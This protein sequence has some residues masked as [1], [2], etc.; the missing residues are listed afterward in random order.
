VSLDSLEFNLVL[1]KQLF[2]EVGGMER[3]ELVPLTCTIVA[4]VPPSAQFFANLL[5]EFL[6][7]LTLQLIQLFLFEFELGKKNQFITNAYRLH[8]N[9]LSLRNIQTF[10][11]KW[12]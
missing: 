8:S 12:L 10:L 9:L 2:R 7:M 5:D 11:V 3:F 4:E 1:L 6:Q